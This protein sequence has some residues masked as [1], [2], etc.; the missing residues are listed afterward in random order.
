MTFP[1]DLARSFAQLNRQVADNERRNRNRKRSG[2]VVE[3]D[4]ARGLARVDLAAEGAKYPFISPWLPW[5]ETSMG[6]NR[7]HTP[8]VLGQEVAVISES[9]ELHDG[10]IV[11]SLP[12]EN[13]ARPSEAGDEY[14]LCFIGSTKVTA[15]DGELIFEADKIS[16]R[17]DAVST[18][19]E[20]VS[21]KANEVS[22][23]AGSV[24][25][26]ASTINSNVPVET[27]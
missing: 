14:I 21:T 7:T 5:R 18:E 22:T 20:T 10:E 3:V 6:A 1:N 8:V 11:A 17:G 15:K 2:L 13:F 4:A 27:N 24:N 25:F 23:E 16:F 9:G 26:D 19:A 12:S